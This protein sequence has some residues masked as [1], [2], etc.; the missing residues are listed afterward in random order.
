[1]SFLSSY[2]R[3]PLNHHSN[4][5]NTNVK[6]KAEIAALQEAARMASHA[7]LA[8]KQQIAT[9]ALES[10]NSALQKE[11]VHLRSRVADLESELLAAHEKARQNMIPETTAIDNIETVTP[12]HD[13]SESPVNDDYNDDDA[14]MVNGVQ[15][16]VKILDEDTIIP[17]Q[18]FG[19]ENEVNE[20]MLC[21]EDR[22]R[23][24]SE[25]QKAVN[26]AEKGR[27]SA[28]ELTC[29]LKNVLLKEHLKNG[30]SAQILVTK[31]LDTVEAE[32]ESC[33]RM[34]VENTKLHGQVSKVVIVIVIP[35]AHHTLSGPRHNS[36]NL[37]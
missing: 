6:L 29:N 31:L 21:L 3:V 19:A 23:E 36:L 12:S 18:K 25:L 2:P 27:A 1:M 35:W 17:P 33:R 10:K 13:E 16:H 37:I 26:T 4:F 5:Q 34:E 28:E 24:L 32:K 30:D 8:T 20:L 7:K 11:I 9:E 22:N 15:Q 14:S